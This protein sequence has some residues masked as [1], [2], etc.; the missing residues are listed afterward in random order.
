[1]NFC[2]L[3]DSNYLNRGLALYV[4]LKKVC[5]EFKLYVVTFDDLAYEKLTQTGLTSLVVER[6]QDFETQELLAVKSTRTRAEYCWTCGPSVIYHFMEK[7]HLDSCHTD[8]FLFVHDD[9]L[10]TL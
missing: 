8:S 6:L 7:Y 2:T 3:F 5:D 4:S 10:Y 9:V 1:M